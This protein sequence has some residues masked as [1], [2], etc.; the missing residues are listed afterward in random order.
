M[1]KVNETQNNRESRVKKSTS[2]RS[3]CSLSSPYPLVSGP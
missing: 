3:D 2:V 1:L